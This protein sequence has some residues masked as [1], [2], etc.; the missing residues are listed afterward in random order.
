M[1]FFFFFKNDFPS[2]PEILGYSSIKYNKYLIV[3]TFS[4]FSRRSERKCLLTH[5]C[6]R[7]REV[8]ITKLRLIKS[9]ERTIIL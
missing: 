3:C 6:K 1:I 7:Q 9:K 2:F 4:G 8:R 5:K